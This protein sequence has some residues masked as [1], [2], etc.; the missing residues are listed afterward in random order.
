MPRLALLCLPLILIACGTPQERCI[1]GVTRELRVINGLVAET[2]VNLARGYSLE[3]QVIST[4][5]WVYCDQ[6]VLVTQPDGSQSWA[7]GGGM[8]MED[9]ARTIER[10][11]AIDPAL[12]RRKLDGLLQQQARLKKQAAP[13]IAQ[14]Q[15]LYPE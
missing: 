11:R 15:A 13:A 10:P 5:V 3:E 14:C 8:C 1:S 9:S 12:E 7:L 4:P 2:E 6:P